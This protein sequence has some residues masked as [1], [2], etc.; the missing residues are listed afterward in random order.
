MSL[1]VLG[2]RAWDEAVAYL[3]GDVY[4]GAAYHGL[5][6]ANGDGAPQCLRVTDGRHHLLVPGLV[7]AIPG[8]PTSDLQSCNGYGGP[9]A[10]DGAPPDF[11]ERAWSIW[12]DAERERGVVA[13]LFRLHPLVD[14]QRWLPADARVL[15]DRH[16][17]YIPLDGGLEAAWRDAEPR[18]RNMVSR[19]RRDG[20]TPVWSDE[21][22]RFEA[23]YDE[24]MV[25]LAAPRSLRFPPGYFARLRALP[26]AEC[27]SVADDRGLQ[28]AAVFLW[29]P[30][31]GHY[32]LSARRADAPNY[33]MNLL[34]QAAL[35]RAHERTLRGVHL[36]GGTSA[37][38]NNP[39]FR[40][41]RSLGG[42]LTPFR[43]A[44]VIVDT[45]RFDALNDAWHRRSGRQPSWLLGY[46]QSLP[47]KVEG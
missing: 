17:V 33:S 1:D 35:E 47:P 23:L 24:A 4:F 36:G 14:N 13:A 44:R 22:A 12:R 15:D 11:L 43:V 34:L 3:A 25:R 9:L 7:T 5:Y 42:E 28:A 26:W 2:A 18:H 16:T 32:H 37:G 19:G 39:L 29:G 8:E 38:D 6:E 27:V 10:S 45:D 21:W 30:T 31:L 46:R 20:V 41:K 40:F